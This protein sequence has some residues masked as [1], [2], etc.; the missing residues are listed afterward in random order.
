MRNN[1]KL[2]REFLRLLLS[3]IGH[4]AVNPSSMGNIHR[5]PVPSGRKEK[6]YYHKKI[7]AATEETL[8]HP[9]RGRPPEEILELFSGCPYK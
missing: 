4:G 9:G 7:D 5:L 1:K 6:T 2:L 3:E 8:K